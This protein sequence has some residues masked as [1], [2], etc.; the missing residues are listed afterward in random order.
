MIQIDLLLIMFE[1]NKVYTEK[2]VKND[3]NILTKNVQTQKSEK[4]RKT[5]DI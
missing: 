4:E 1:Y 5:S 3:V 2:Y